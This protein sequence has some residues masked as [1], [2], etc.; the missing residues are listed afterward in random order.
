MFSIECVLYRMCS[1][2]C[3]CALPPA[4]VDRYLVQSVRAME[5]GR[6]GERER[7]RRSIG[8]GD[9][10]KEDK[11]KETGSAGRLHMRHVVLLSKTL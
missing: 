8:V 9:K 1:V 6:E 11:T 2:F 5:G 7:A 10:E 4:G 3:K